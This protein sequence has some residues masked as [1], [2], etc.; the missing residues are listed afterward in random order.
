MPATVVVGLQWGDE[1]KAKVLDELSARADIVCRFQGGANAGH[2]VVVDGEKYKF[3]LVPCGVARPGKPCYIGNGVALDLVSLLEEIRH[4]EERGLEV[5]NRL[6]ISD[7]AHLVMP[8]HK[9]LEALA[10]R[11]RGK[12]AIGT[13]LRGIGPCYTDKVARTGFRMADIVRE[14]FRPR[15]EARLR[16]VNAIVERVHGEK[17]IAYE[18]AVEPALAAARELGALVGDVSALVNDALDEGKEVLFEGAQAT[19][20]DVDFGTYPYVTSSN[21]SALGVSAGAG[22]APHRISYVTGLLK[23]YTTRVGGGP[24]PTEDTGEAGSRL[25][26]RGAEFGTTTGRPRRCGWFD[27]VASRYTTRLNA[28]HGVAI[29]KLDVLSGEPTVKVATAYTLPDGSVTDRF[30]ATLHDLAGARPVYEEHEGWSEDIGAARAPDDL[31]PAARRY[32]ERITELV[33]A[34][35][36]LVSVG[37]DR[38]ATIRWES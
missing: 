30:P 36:A 18:E 10:E 17:P 14:D 19:L 29:S 21:A 9:T 25:R 11:A 27:A 26:E 2:T 23:A 32:V 16:D 37:E 8:Y 24:F 3:H 13:T 1:G 7:R 35:A 4:F 28:V 22:C 34:R 20:L 33:G 15:A 6:T 38:G 31:P 5:K 12:D